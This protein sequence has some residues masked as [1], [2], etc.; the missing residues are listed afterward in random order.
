MK[1]LLVY[2][3]YPE[4]FWSFKYALK[5]I[6]KKASLPPLGLLTVAA[7]LPKEWEKKLVDMTV[8]VL[9]DRDIKWADYV[10]VSAMSIQKESVKKIIAQCK[11]LRTKMVAG[12][13]FF[14]SG[15]EDFG[16]DVDHFIL[17]EA[18]ITLPLFLEDLE[19]GHPKHIYTSDQW[20][21]IKKTPIP[22]W[23]L[24]DI[25]KY[26]NMCIQYS[27]GCPFNCD[28]CDVTFLF[29]HKMRLKTKDQ[30]LTE[31]DSLYSRGWRGGVF[32][33][34]DNFIGNKRELK[35]EVLPAMIHWMEERKYP[36]NFTTQASI[37]LSDDEELM[38]LM[39][40]AGF[41]SVFVG[42]ET[43]NEESLAECNKLQNK[44]RDLIACVKKI[45]KFGLVVNGGFI[46][47]FDND[48]PAIFEKI[49]DFIQ[50]SGIVSAMVGL[51]NAPQGTKLYQRLVKEN[52]LLKEATG[53][54]TDLSINFIPK[55]NYKT[56]IV[57]YKRVLNTIYSPKCYYERLLTLLKNMRPLKKKRYQ[58]HLWYITA[59]LKSIWQLG[60]IGKERIYYWKIFF[61]TLF[62]RPQLL[63]TAITY[64]VYG[65]HFRK[66]YENY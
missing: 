18:E 13:P 1:I 57:G 8:T 46:M 51:L 40:Q 19:R 36:F 14:T 50:K 31:L 43:P 64:A 25:N 42:I 34:D 38:R 59:F 29:G 66:I 10:F 4:T 60:I 26:V 39:V 63:P 58:F 15:Y 49:V 48:T 20:A 2:P 23:E 61:W 22:L 44:N 37:N 16:D 30:I 56:L 55:M 41:A 62:R 54:N 47:G 33:V 45:Q 52:R 32:I 3:E 27:R 5:F 21:D 7:L 17:N 12:G 65:F 24:A 35:I 53:D 28:F 9:S 6:S 11:R